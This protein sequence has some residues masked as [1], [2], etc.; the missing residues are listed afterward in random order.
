MTSAL[1]DLS[2][3]AVDCLK[4]IYKLDERGERVTTSSMRERL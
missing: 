3:R 1:R 4:F 2:V